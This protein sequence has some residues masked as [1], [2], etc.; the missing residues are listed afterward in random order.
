MHTRWKINGKYFK[1]ELLIMNMH[2]IVLKDT[3][4]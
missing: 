1:F 3:L 2:L 4:E